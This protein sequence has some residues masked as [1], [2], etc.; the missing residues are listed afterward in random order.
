MCK[1]D[2]AI[3]ELHVGAEAAEA[4]SLTRVIHYIL[5]VMILR[6]E[7]VR[8]LLLKRQN[9]GEA[10]RLVT[11]FTDRFGVLRVVAKGVRRIPSRR[12]GHL[13]PL[14]EI[15]GIVHG[16]RGRYY[17]AAIE[18]VDHFPRLAA[19]RTAV[20]R[21]SILAGTVLALFEQEDPQPE[22]FSALEQGFSL[23]PTLPAPKRSLL[24]AAFCLYALHKAGLAPQLNACLQC[25][26][27]APQEAV[28]LSASDG[29]WRCLS[30]HGSLAGTRHSLSLRQL[31]ALR[32]LQA[33]PAK[34]LRL[35][36]TEDE[37]IQIT[38]AV[39]AYLSGLTDWSF[40]PQSAAGPFAAMPVLAS[41]S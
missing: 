24:E 20:A 11:L 5:G 38:D 14:T 18:T 7:T 10:D 12:G 17:L 16:Q 13:E 23:L 30:C 25:G 2:N 15:V 9:Y 29:G 26:A 27:P 1:K 21:A 33:Y 6:R 37:S 35:A 8:A 36:V 32:Y 31:R 40:A 3:F 28:V 41:F 19:D 22:L 4:C 39:R 34:A